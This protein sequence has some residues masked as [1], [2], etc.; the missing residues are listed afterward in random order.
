[1]R[2]PFTSP[3]GLI[4]RNQRNTMR[5]EPVSTTMMVASAIGGGMSLYGQSK[6][7]KAQKQASAEA[8]A[9]QDA[10][11]AALAKERAGVE[12]VAAGQARAAAGGG[13]GLLAYTDDPI[14]LSSRLK[15][16]LTNKLRTRFGAA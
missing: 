6:Q 12:A 10:Q 5:R 2:D 4:R 8:K 14:N 1:M 13:G 15:D 16:D 11:A 3:D 7:S 9:A